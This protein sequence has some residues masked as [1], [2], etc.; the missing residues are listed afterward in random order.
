LGRLELVDDPAFPIVCPGRKTLVIYHLIF[1][2]FHL[3]GSNNR[4][5]N[6]DLA[7]AVCDLVRRAIEG[8]Y[9]PL[10]L[11]RDNAARLA[12]LAAFLAA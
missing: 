8:G 11:L 9:M 12:V 4:H 2:I 6:I 10:E 3:S 1:L 5:C 7:L